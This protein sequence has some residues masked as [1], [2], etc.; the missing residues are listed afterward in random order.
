[1]IDTTQDEYK[2]MNKLGVCWNSGWRETE[3]Q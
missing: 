3:L 1:M 2:D